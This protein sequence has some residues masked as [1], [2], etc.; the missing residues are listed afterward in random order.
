V[1]FCVDVEGQADVALGG[2]EDGFATREAGIVDED[3]G[4]S[5]MCFDVVGRALDLVGRCEVTVEV[6]YI[7][8]R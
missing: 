8:R 2:F 5:E 4:V 7:W 3:C 1:R 6:V